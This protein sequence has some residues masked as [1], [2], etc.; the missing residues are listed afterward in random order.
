MRIK[1]LLAVVAA[2]ALTACSQGGGAGGD[3]AGDGP[4]TGGTATRDLVVEIDQGDGS[5][6][7]R[8]TLTCGDVV[9]GDLP[10]GRAACAHLADLEDPFAPVPDDAICTE[11]YGGP[12]TAHVT[13]TWDGE[14]V[15]LEL[16]R[17]NGCFISQWDS[18][19]PLLPGP[20]GVAPPS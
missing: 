3:G 1:L 4:A 15:D 10:D 17:V 8:Y 19:V 6:A 14:P 12:Q 5:R 7:E 18:L 16:S 11:L 2:A 20:V 9:E 13:G